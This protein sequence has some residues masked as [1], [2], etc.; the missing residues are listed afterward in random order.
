MDRKYNIGEAIREIREEKGASID[1]I[2]N[3]I[4]I[5]PSLLSQIENHMTSPS[6]G[7][8]I[9]ISKAL[10]VSLGRILGEEGKEFYSI[11][12]K[13]ER[14]S[15]HRYGTKEGVGYG[16]S[17]ESLA[18]GMK[19]RNMEPF[20]VTLEIVDKNLQ[21]LSKHEGEEFIFVLEGTVEVQLA[22]MKDTL[23]PGDSIYY[24]SEIPH[25]VRALGNLPAKIVAVIF[26][27]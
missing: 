20:L 9:K 17:Y 24:K 6:L 3:S 7:A 21:K 12:R 11:V 8:L 27:G 26:T 1:E 18:V 13:G 19:E 2:A 5:S 25:L 22:E 16:Y 4:G 10:N 15:T 14:H 23:Y